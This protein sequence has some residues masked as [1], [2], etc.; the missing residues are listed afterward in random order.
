MRL[1]QYGLLL[2]VAP[3]LRAQT[4]R[5]APAP[6]VLFG[7]VVPAKG[8]ATRPDTIAGSRRRDVRYTLVGGLLGAGLGLAFL[9]LD[10]G[11]SVCTTAVPPT[12]YDR[13]PGAELV[14]G[15]ALLGAGAGFILSRTAPTRVVRPASDTL[16]VAP[17]PMDRGV[18]AWQGAVIG[19]VVGGVALP[20]LASSLRWTESGDGVPAIAFAPLGA[21]IGLVVGGSL[22]QGQ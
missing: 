12:C 13:G 15:G 8:T 11:A 10:D 16:Q 20:I 5:I 17:L 22:A 4:P 7:A 21:L 18:K 14:V 19:T 3:A 2:L 6:S 9:L 1:V